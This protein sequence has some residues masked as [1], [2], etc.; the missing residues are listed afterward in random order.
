[1]PNLG[2]PLVR[3]NGTAAEAWY[4]LFISMY[5]VTL[6]GLPVLPSGVVPGNPNSLTLASLNGQIEN[7]QGQITTGA[8]AIAANTSSIATLQSDVIVLQT[9]INTLQAQVNALAA[10]LDGLNVSGTAGGANAGGGGAPPAT[11]QTYMAIRIGTSNFRVP[12]YNP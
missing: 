12:L 11:V 8:G 4:R 7:Q 3:E 9:E 10:Q 6:A 1:M 5:N 2:V